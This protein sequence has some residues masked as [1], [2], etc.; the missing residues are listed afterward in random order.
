VPH[1]T[2]NDYLFFA[3]RLL[4][5]RAFRVKSQSNEPKRV[6]DC[7]KNSKNRINIYVFPFKAMAIMASYCFFIHMNVKEFKPKIHLMKF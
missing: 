2:L 4:Q 7:K 1:Q 3:I 5:P 6:L